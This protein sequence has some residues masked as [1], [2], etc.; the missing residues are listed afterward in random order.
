MFKPMAYTI[1]FAILGAFILSITY[2]PMMSALSLSKN[3]SHKNTLA[4]K[5]MAKIESAY[6]P[7]LRK[8][9]GIS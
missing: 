8:L 2:V 9:L 3:L 6:Q 4:D 7:L 1:A 5:L